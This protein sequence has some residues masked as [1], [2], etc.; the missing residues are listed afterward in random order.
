M[1]K[2]VKSLG[3]VKKPL[4]MVAPKEPGNVPLSE[5]SIIQKG[6][7]RG[8]TY[9]EIRD[10]VNEDRKDNER[11][12]ST[13]KKG[14]FN[15]ISRVISNK[16]GM[17]DKAEEKWADYKEKDKQFNSLIKSTEQIKDSKTRAKRERSASL[18]WN[19]PKGRQTE[20]IASYDAETD[21][22]ILCTP[23]C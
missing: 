17:V 21:D 20:L 5:I 2:H 14:M 22:M 9:K 10:R 19:K 6:S 16:G 13:G 12:V 7:A 11:K 18:I 15:L 4:K 1:T 23:P 8:Q 3:G